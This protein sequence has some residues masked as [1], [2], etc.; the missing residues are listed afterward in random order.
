MIWFVVGLAVLVLLG[1]WLELL[2][3]IV[4]L[5][6]IGKCHDGYA[7]TAEDGNGKSSRPL[8][9]LNVEHYGRASHE[10]QMPELRGGA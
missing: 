4:V 3:R 7:D 6:M 2:A 10:H 5:H 9:R 8:R 1:I